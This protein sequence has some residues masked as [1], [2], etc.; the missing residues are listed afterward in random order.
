MIKRNYMLRFLRY[1]KLLNIFKYT[2]LFYIITGSSVFAQ[3]VYSLQ[4]FHQI[5]KFAQSQSE[6]IRNLDIDDKANYYEYLLNSAIYNG[7]INFGYGKINQKNPVVSQYQT[8]DLSQDKYAITL[9]QKLP[10]GLE[11]SIR[12]DYAAVNSSAFTQNY[13]YDK[14]F[15]AME[16][17][18]DLLKNIFGRM[19]KSILT[20]A[21]VQKELNSLVLA[22]RKAQ[23]L[24]KVG[25]NILFLLQSY[26]LQSFQK[27][28][29]NNL[30][31][32]FT[33]NRK[34]YK[35]KLLEEADYLL[36][37]LQYQQCST[38]LTKMISSGEILAKQLAYLLS[39]KN[40]NTKYN[41][42][43]NKNSKTPIFKLNIKDGFKLSDNFKIAM[44]KF[45]IKSNYESYKQAEFAKSID[46]SVAAKV[47]NQAQNI[48]DDPNSTKN[49]NDYAYPS[50]ELNLQ[51]KIPLGNKKKQANYNKEY[52][53]WRLQKLKYTQLENQITSEYKTILSEIEQNTILRNSLAKQVFL[54][55]KIFQQR[56]KDFILGRIRTEEIIKIQDDLTSTSEEYSRAKFSILFFQLKYLLLSAK[57]SNYFK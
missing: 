23:Y 25:E 32:L 30:K 56:K 36:S 3:S 17:K 52:L 51:I 6:I 38:K 35:N 43:L 13:Q 2:L 22:E 29:C 1:F 24:Y 40:K 16:L 18:I 37:K 8:S 12:G 20:Q 44:A 19:D 9:T 26:D 49:I 54:R 50:S 5:I 21:K 31:S 55:K 46:I 39:S 28:R 45:M 4:E 11:S 14:V 10:Y 34:K 41:I 7:D 53:Q 47:S 33:I 57:I 42:S 27:S 15:L 48:Y